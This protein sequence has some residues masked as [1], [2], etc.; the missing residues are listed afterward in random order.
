MAYNRR[1]K[2]RYKRKSKSL[3]TA[4]NAMTVAKDAWYLS[5]KLARVVNVEKKHHELEGSVTP[6]NTAALA[7]LSEF[8]SGSNTLALGDAGDDRDGNSVKPL[9]WSINFLITQHAS[10]TSTMVRIIIFKWDKQHG[11]DA[12]AVTDYL[13]DASFD[14]LSLKRYNKRFQ[15][16]TLLDKTFHLS[17]AGKTL[18]TYN[19]RKKL[20]GHIQY[21]GATADPEIGGYYML[22]IS[23]E[24]TNEPTVQFQSRITFADN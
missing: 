20:Y 21:D 17:S 16:S 19:F 6:G 8:T 15:F 9:F 7:T 12:P 14:Y 3:Y 4:K 22:C 23:N 1:Y 18:A 2:R 10:A 13:R 24:G 5:K 11:Q